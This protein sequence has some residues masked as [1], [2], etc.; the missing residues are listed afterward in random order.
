VEPRIVDT[1]QVGLSALLA[2]LFG[3]RDRLTIPPS[4]VAH[5][6]G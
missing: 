2:A 3:L 5:D 6:G 4:V 1:D